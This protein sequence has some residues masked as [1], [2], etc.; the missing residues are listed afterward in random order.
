MI[1][2]LTRAA[3]TASA[4]RSA[5]RAAR[6]QLN[7]V[8]VGDVGNPRT[9]CALLLAILER[10]GPMA[11]WLRERGIDEPTLRRMLG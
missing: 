8:P 7:V 4:R 9:D 1:A 6:A 3:A 11:A 5:R 10:G 2:R